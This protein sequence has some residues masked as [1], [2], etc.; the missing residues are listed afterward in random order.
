MATFLFV[1]LLIAV[2]V[3]VCGMQDPSSVWPWSVTPRRE[4][5]VAT[6]GCASFFLLLVFAGSVAHEQELRRRKVE[7]ERGAASAMSTIN[8]DPISAAGS[9]ALVDSTT[10]GAAGIPGVPP[11]KWAYRDDTDPMTSR[12]EHTATLESE[13]TVSFDFPYNGPQHG[14]L[15]LRSHPSY[16][17]DVMLR[18]ERGQFLCHSYDGCS[19]R[20]RFDEAAAENW[21]ATPPADNS[22]EVIFIRGYDRFLRKLR[23]AE[24]VRISANIYHEGA[25]VFE[26]DVRGFDRAAYT[27]AQ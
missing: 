6:Y 9:T 2:V 11:A 13:N 10:K 3:T 19:V 27:G 15:L 17:H 12:V 20:V 1:L 7:A 18:I 24:T 23:R 22:T 25:P 26:F 14:T 16:G 4:V 5:V 8:R 21:S